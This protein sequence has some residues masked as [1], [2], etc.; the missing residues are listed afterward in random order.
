MGLS[1]SQERSFGGAVRHRRSDKGRAE[2]IVVQ[3]LNLLARDPFTTSLG[4]LAS[5]PG[6][7]GGARAGVPSGGSGQRTVHRSSV[8]APLDRK[9]RFMTA[10]GKAHYCRQVRMSA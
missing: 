6:R 1:P 4:S 5:T 2:K 9:W 3:P 7:R 8:L 10:G